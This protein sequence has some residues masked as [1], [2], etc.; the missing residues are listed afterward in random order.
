MWWTVIR[1]ARTL[2]LSEKFREYREGIVGLK[3]AVKDL[4]KTVLAGAADADKEL[5]FG[6]EPAEIDARVYLKS[7]VSR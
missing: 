5:G 7:L 1:A 6:P 4:V 2:P 3:G